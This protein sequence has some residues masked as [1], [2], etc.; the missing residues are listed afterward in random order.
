MIDNIL[1]ET[2]A[3]LNLAEALER[4]GIPA[5]V[6]KTILFKFVETNSDKAVLMQE[7]LDAGEMDDL[8]RLVHTLKGASGNIGA[9]ELF[10]AALAVEAELKSKETPASITKAIDHLAAKL[11]VVLGSLEEL[12]QAG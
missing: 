1:P 11:Q 5:Q 8:A 9:E 7:S 12:Q 3:G 10:A 4:V 6:F 2:M